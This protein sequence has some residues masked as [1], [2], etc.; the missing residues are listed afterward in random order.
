MKEEMTYHTLDGP[1][2]SR[3]ISLLM[4]KD[5]HSGWSDRY[6]LSIHANVCRFILDQDPHP[7]EHVPLPASGWRRRMSGRA[8]RTQRTETLF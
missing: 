4:S 7:K 8:M 1:A 5:E 6:V 2:E 3:V